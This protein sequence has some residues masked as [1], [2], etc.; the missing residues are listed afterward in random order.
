MGSSL[1]S[2]N[3]LPLPVCCQWCARQP[4]QSQAS[5]VDTV[6]FLHSS[7]T[8]QEEKAAMKPL[9]AAILVYSVKTVILESIMTHL[10]F[11]RYL[12]LQC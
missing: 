7:Q 3:P 11:S 8:W 9:L 4:S 12:H 5:A 1:N 10:S 6:T 2:F